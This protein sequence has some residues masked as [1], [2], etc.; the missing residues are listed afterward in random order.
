V[1]AYRQAAVT[2]TSGLV[3]ESPGG[4]DLKG[5]A[6][7]DSANTDANALPTNGAL[8]KAATLVST[9]A[10]TITPT[11]QPGTGRN[12]GVFV[13]NDSGN[14]LNLYEGVTTFTI[15]GTWRGAAQTST[16]TLTSTAGNKAIADGKFRYVYGTKPFDTVTSVT[17]NNAPAA[18]LKLSLG[19]GSKLGLYRDLVTPAEAD[20][21]KLVKNATDLAVTGLVDTT[22]MTVNFGALAD[23]DDVEIVY[24]AGVATTSAQ[25]ALAEVTASTNLAGITFVWLAEGW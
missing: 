4:G 24:K 3:T 5:S 19:P 14:P 2:S 21:V 12:I 18:T 22:N 10:G 25:V 1:K 6:N 20:V 11:V 23:G 17:Y 9:L 7:T 13:T 8:Y 15:T 16:I